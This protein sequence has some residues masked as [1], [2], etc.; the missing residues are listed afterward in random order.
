[1]YVSNTFWQTISRSLGFFNF[2]YSGAITCV[3]F[4]KCVTSSW[5]YSG[6]LS[7]FPA[8]QSLDLLVQHDG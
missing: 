1:M 2:Q 6:K 3:E 4:C 7:D 5:N 8:F